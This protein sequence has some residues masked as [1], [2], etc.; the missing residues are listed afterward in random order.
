MPDT[1]F[2]TQIKTL[3]YTGVFFVYKSKN[4]IKNRKTTIWSVLYI[5]VMYYGK[6]KLL[7]IRTA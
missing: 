2:N 4:K 6:D 5:L 1:S 3:V 7:D